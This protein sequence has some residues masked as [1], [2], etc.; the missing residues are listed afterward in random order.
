MF[1]QMLHRKSPT[2]PNGG[3][4]GVNEME[5]PAADGRFKSPPFFSRVPLSMI[6]TSADVWISRPSTCPNY[7]RRS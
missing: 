4:A 5:S 2:W 7:R 6:H 3:T 1:I